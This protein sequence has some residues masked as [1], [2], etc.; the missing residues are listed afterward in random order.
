[1]TKYAGLWK[2]DDGLFKWNLFDIITVYEDLGLAMP[3][4]TFAENVAHSVALREEKCCFKDLSYG[5]NW[6]PQRFDPLQNLVP[7]NGE[8]AWK[9]NGKWRAHPKGCLHSTAR[10]ATLFG[11]LG[12]IPSYMGVWCVPRVWGFCRGRIIRD[13]GMRSDDV[14][15]GP[16]KQVPV[17]PRGGEADLDLITDVVEYIGPRTH[18]LGAE[19][20]RNCVS[21]SRE[22]RHLS[23]LW[24]MIGPFTFPW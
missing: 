20:R 15:N 24:V 13:R 3:N 8:P 12:F 18:P 10:D 16:V 7:G 1:M 5:Y 2:W 11:D 4:S 21:A 19:E 9:L 14:R 23:F 17:V 22:G 6:V